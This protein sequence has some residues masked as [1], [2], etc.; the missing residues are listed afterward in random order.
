MAGFGDE[1]VDIVDWIVRVTHW[2]WRDKNVGLI[3]D[4]YLDNS[5]VHVGGGTI[6]GR[7]PMVVDT[8]NTIAAYPAAQGCFD[9]V[10]W[11]GN[12]RDGF[13]T[14][15][16][17]TTIGR[18]TGCTSL[19]AAHQPAGPEDRH[20]ALLRQRQPYHRGVERARRPGHDHRSG[21]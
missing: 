2:I 4:Y 1:F 21:L 18:N 14:S 10:V 7:E 15:H 8:V 3:Y 19:W 20:R 9:D 6:H 11:T 16:R 5:I 13:Y 17:Y 12:D